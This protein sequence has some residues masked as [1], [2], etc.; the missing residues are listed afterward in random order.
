M[1][2]HPTRKHMWPMTL[3]FWGVEDFWAIVDEIG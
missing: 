2:I 1:E 3:D